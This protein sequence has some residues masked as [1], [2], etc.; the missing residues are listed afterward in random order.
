MH[1][2]RIKLC[3]NKKGSYIHSNSADYKIFTDSSVSLR[4]IYL[5]QNQIVN[6]VNIFFSADTS[7]RGLPLSVSLL[8]ARVSPNFFSSLLMLLFC[9]AFVWKFIC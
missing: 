7:L 8:P 9:P 2:L 5:T 3:S 4:H 6:Q 1:L